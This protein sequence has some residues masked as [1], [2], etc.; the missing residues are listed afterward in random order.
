MDPQYDLTNKTL[1]IFN[2]YY[3]I[4]YE[5]QKMDNK[6]HTFYQGN[7]DFPCGLWT[8]SNLSPDPYILRIS[9]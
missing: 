8:H 4:F 2:L 7:K 3:L 9:K 5:L 1:E 6:L